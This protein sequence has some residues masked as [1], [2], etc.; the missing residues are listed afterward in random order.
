VRKLAA[1][2]RADL[3]AV[4][5]RELARIV[6]P[7]PYEVVGDNIK[8]SKASLEI[9]SSNLVIGG[10]FSTIQPMLDASGGVMSKEV[11]TGCDEHSTGDRTVRLINPKR[12]MEL[13]AGWR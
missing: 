5:E 11:A 13:L 6:G 3:G 4:I 8:Q 2:V 10:M 9:V 7:L 12:S 1:A